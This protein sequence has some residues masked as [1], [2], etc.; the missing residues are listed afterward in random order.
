MS[1]EHWL[2]WLYP[3]PERMVLVPFNFFKCLHLLLLE[4]HLHS[5]WFEML[6]HG[7]INW[8][9]ILKSLLSLYQGIHFR[10]NPISKLYLPFLSSVMFCMS[11][12]CPRHNLLPFN[13][14]KFRLL[15][16][17]IRHPRPHHI[18][19]KCCPERIV[20]LWR[21]YLP[22]SILPNFLFP[23]RLKSSKCN[24]KP[25]VKPEIILYPLISYFSYNEHE[26]NYDCHL[27]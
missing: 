14:L 17:I 22:C 10:L 18:F 9:F 7:N 4:F 2:L 20:H 23:S 1:M 6:S 5:L 3:H 27:S 16:H 12:R 26:S 13:F 8:R 25:I 15:P 11:F 21:F 19:P 24:S